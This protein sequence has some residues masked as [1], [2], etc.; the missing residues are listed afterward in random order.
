MIVAVIC[1]DEKEA[2]NVATSFWKEYSALLPSR[3]EKEPAD[4]FN[5]FDLEKIDKEQFL[6]SAWTRR[7]A[8]A[9]QYESLLYVLFC[10]FFQ[11]DVVLSA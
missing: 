5:I 2:K 9:A 3:P 8:R 7:R 11:Q 1:T 6:Q 4:R 10:F